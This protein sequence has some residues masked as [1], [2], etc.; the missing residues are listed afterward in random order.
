MPMDEYGRA[1]R[2]YDPIVGPALR[3]IH[4]DM[5]NTLLNA[6]PRSIV[7]LCCGTGQFTGM[8]TQA[9]IDTT[10]VDLSPAMLDVA[11]TKR[12]GVQ[13]IHADAAALPFQDSTFDGAV[14]SFALHEKP[15]SLAVSILREARRIVHPG[16]LI[17]VADYRTPAPR[18]SPWT[19]LSI[20]LI[21]RL[22]GKQHYQYFKQYMSGGGTYA[23]FRQAGMS[24]ELAGI[25][26][27][28]WAG[29]FVAI[30]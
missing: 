3:S 18:S 19:G 23:L 8:A 29:I 27:N 5:L 9:R 26:L 12:T 6:R 15:T 16:G 1:A 10:G 25:H 21:E 13:F 30:S 14:V 28:G 17:V 24:V 4:L 11:R 20:Q 22:A 7:D 2:L